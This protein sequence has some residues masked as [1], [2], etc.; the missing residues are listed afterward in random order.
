[1]ID[2]VRHVLDSYGLSFRYDS[3][4][5]IVEWQHPD[6][7]QGGDDAGTVLLSSVLSLCALNCVPRDNLK[8]H[9]NAI[10]TSRRFNP[11][12]D[13]LS[14]LKWD[15]KPRFDAL[16]DAMEADDPAICRIALRVF[17]IQACAAGDHAETAIGLHPDYRAHFESIL[18]FV[19]GQGIGKTKGLRKLLPLKLRPRFKEGLL[20]NLRDKDSVIAAVS[21]WVVELGELEATF[22][23][24]DIA[25]LKAF[26]SKDTDVIRVPYGATWTEFARRT[27]F[28]GTVNDVSFLADET[29]NRRFVPMVVGLID[30]GWRDEEIEQVWAE[31]WFRYASGEKWWPSAEEDVLLAANAEEYRGKTALEE[32]IEDAFDWGAP[33]RSVRVKASTVHDMVA[34]RGRYVGDPTMKT[35]KTVGTTLRRLWLATGLVRK[36]RGTL[37]VKHDDEWVRVLASNGKNRGWL[38]PPL[39]AREPGWKGDTEARLDEIKR[40]VG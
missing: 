38:L 37:M 30:V 35:L 3:I 8:T 32:A 23:K 20:L 11:V 22:K 1:H 34:V 27:C 17:F 14:S 10:A 39:V 7:E 16:A 9:M 26:I 33:P 4:S 40:R 12:V 15:G 36:M 13:H 5:K 19:G 21:G 25:E 28:A 18:V 29:G 24:T 2:N 6:I 31:A